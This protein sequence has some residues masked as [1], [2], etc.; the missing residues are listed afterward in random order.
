LSEDEHGKVQSSPKYRDLPF[1]A[2]Y[3][4]KQIP[5]GVLRFDKSYSGSEKRFEGLETPGRDEDLPIGARSGNGA[6]E[7][8]SPGVAAA[9]S[10]FLGKRGFLVAQY[11]SIKKFGLLYTR[12]VRSCGESITEKV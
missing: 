4:A 7:S 11:R 10:F 1:S 5:T 3:P 8:S 9:S 6:V 12:Y 2:S